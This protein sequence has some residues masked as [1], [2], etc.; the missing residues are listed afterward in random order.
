MSEVH[1]FIDS[2]ITNGTSGRFADIMNPATGEVQGKVALASAAEL[3][4]AVSI[5]AEAPAK[6]GR[7]QPGKG[8]AA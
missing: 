1:H 4:C 3:N 5:A 6:M 2:K 8:A 7:E